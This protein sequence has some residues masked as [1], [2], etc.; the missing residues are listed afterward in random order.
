MA[1]GLHRGRRVPAVER[2]RRHSDLN[3]PM[4]ISIK[5]HHSSGAHMGRVLG[6]TS[7]PDSEFMLS[8]FLMDAWDGIAVIEDAITTG[9]PAPEAA[10][11]AA[12]RVK[13]AASSNDFPGI[14]VL[15]GTMG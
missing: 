6:V 8:V 4:P 13:E 11:A 2:A 9:A 10:L 7:T 15:A 12:R 1:K 14:S 5:K 3:A